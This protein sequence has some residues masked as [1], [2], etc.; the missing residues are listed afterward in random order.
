MPLSRKIQLDTSYTD[1]YIHRSSIAIA[2]RVSCSDIE[3][4]MK[5]LYIGIFLV[6]EIEVSKIINT[7][8]KYSIDCGG[9]VCMRLRVLSAN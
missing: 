2:Y 5:A 9:G 3:L 4:H 6:H 8:T 1:P 7:R